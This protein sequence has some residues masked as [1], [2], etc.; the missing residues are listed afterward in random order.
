MGSARR[1]RAVFG[2]PPKTLFDKSF[3]K[4]KGGQSES[5][6]GLGE[7]PTPAR[8]PRALL[9]A[10]SGFGLIEFFDRGVLRS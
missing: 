7:P 3:H 1:R 6:E 8:E 5:N 10:I 4:E 9:F 2:G